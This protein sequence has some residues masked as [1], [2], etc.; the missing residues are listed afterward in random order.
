[1]NLT[2]NVVH[3]A[4]YSTGEQRGLLDGQHVTGVRDDFG[5]GVRDAVAGSL[6]GSL[7]VVHGAAFTEEQK[8]RSMDP[9]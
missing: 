4:Q 2:V 6:R 9:A 5:R 1:V 7:R 3:E 8:S